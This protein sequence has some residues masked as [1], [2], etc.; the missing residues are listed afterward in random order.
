MSFRNLGRD[1]KPGALAV[2]VALALALGLAGCAPG[3]VTSSE[4]TVNLIITSINDGAQL[5]SDV[6]NGEFSSFI[7]ENEVPV[8]VTVINKNPN[9][10]T[11]SSAST[12]ILESY[13]VR[14]VRSDGRGTEGIDVPYRITGTLTQAVAVGGSVTFPVEV[15]RRQAK[16]DPPLNNI[17]QTTVLTVFAEVSLYGKTVSGQL[18]SASGRLQ[19]DFA[20]FGDVLTA[21]PTT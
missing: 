3:Y 7:C 19:I 11:T 6:R 15:V 18:V 2:C 8:T 1:G 21:C 4:A 16:L 14:Y 10:P 9:S 13:E 20:D 5:D 12:V 17:F